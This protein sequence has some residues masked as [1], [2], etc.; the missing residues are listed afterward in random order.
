MPVRNI[1]IGDI[2]DAQSMDIIGEGAADW[3]KAWNAKVNKFSKVH[4]TT[5]D[6]A[7][8]LLMMDIEV[9]RPSLD[10]EKPPK[11]MACAYSCIKSKVQEC[12]EGNWK[13]WADPEG[14]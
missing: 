7:N 9:L 8:D 3:T 13:Y 14:S 11:C 12:K 5:F 1:T 2:H 4:G 10:E 6:V